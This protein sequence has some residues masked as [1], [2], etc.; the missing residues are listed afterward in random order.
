M[1]P[2]SFLRE[3]VR[4]LGY[5]GTEKGRFDRLCAAE[6]ASETSHSTL[7]HFFSLYI[8]QGAT[9]RL[10][11]IGANDG[12]LDDYVGFMR[13][14]PRVES[15]L[16]EPQPSCHTALRRLATANPRI[17]VLP[18]AL[19]DASGTRTLYRFSRPEER[20][21]QLNVFSSFDRAR[22][23]QAK[24]DL[25]LQSRI[26]YDEVEAHALPELLRRAKFSSID[27]LVADCEGYDHAVVAQALATLD[28]LP[29]I[30][31]FEHRWLARK[32]RNDCYDALDRAGY[33][34]VQGPL[35]A[36]CFRSREAQ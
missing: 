25:S 33:G 17:Q 15:A 4:S 2:R 29:V 35:D 11:Q 34:I 9:A 27:I 14:H 18:Y 32:T 3:L 22:L 19:A 16:V 28:P 5:D 23:D 1:N 21:I 30:L 10:M 8:G 6:R 24:R 12:A 20:G 7:R 36:V 26:V 31:V 13:D